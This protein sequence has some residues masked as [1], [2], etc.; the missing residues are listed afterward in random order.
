MSTRYRRVPLNLEEKIVEHLNEHPHGLTAS[1]VGA[2]FNVVP[3]R[4][5]RILTLMAKRGL[6]VKTGKNDYRHAVFYYPA[7]A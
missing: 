7:G 6:L 4:A 1:D 3:Q 5:G 2:H